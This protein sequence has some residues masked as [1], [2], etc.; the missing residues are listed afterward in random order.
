VP[1]NQGPWVRRRTLICIRVPNL[2]RRI[3]QLSGEA[4][5]L[6]LRELIVNENP[7]WNKYDQQMDE[8]EISEWLCKRV[9][10]CGKKEMRILFGSSAQPV[11]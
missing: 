3:A 1:R 7:I 5:S 4:A 6:S 8:R 9:M 2:Q 11:R 10:N